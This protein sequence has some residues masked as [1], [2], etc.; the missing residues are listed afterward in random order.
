M[1]VAMAVVALLLGLL[2]YFRLHL[3]WRIMAARAGLDDVRPLPVSA[4]PETPVPENWVH[5]RFGSLDFDLP[6]EMAECPVFPKNGATILFFHCGSRSIWVA[7]PEDRTDLLQALPVPPQG[8]GLSLPRLRLACCQVSSDDF[9]WTMS[10]QELAWHAWLIAASGLLRVRSDGRAETLFRQDLE[11]IVFFGRS[12]VSFDWQ[13]KGSNVGGF[14]NFV[15]RSGE[16]DPAWV[17][18]V[19]QSVRFSGQSYPDTMPP[20]KVRALFQVVSEK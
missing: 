13:A 2:M 10:R 20:E 15:D 14:M 1:F 8:R 7:L 6:A 9:R 3:A 16:C 19:C 12:L 17:R 4:M 18:F 5:C 11:G